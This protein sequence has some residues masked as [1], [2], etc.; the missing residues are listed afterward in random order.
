MTFLVCVPRL[1]Q[2]Q[3]FAMGPATAL[4]LLLV[5]G[6]SE[7]KRTAGKGSSVLIPGAIKEG[8]NKNKTLWCLC[9]QMKLCSVVKSSKAFKGQKRFNLSIS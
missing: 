9:R 6:G 7:T 3:T 4:C 8:G 1:V 5:L 2:R